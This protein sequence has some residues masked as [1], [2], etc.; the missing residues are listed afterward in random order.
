MP[1][2]TETLRPISKEHNRWVVLRTEKC[3]QKKRLART[4]R[5]LCGHGSIVERYVSQP[6]SSLPHLLPTIFPSRKQQLASQFV[7]KNKTSPWRRLYPWRRSLLDYLYLQRF[8]SISR[9]LHG[10]LQARLLAR[11]YFKS[12]FLSLL[13][14]S[15]VCCSHRSSQFFCVNHFWSRVLEPNHADFLGYAAWQRF[16][17]RFFWGGSLKAFSA[18]MKRRRSTFRN[19]RF[20]RM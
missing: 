18:R 11:I 4:R 12:L 15:L 14:R 1:F 19:S 20:S 16:W 13:F 7:M 3:E 6:R 10:I 2:C 17:K 8:A 9:I 5:Q